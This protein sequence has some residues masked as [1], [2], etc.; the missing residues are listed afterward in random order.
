MLWRIL[1][2]HIALLRVAL[3]HHAALLWVALIH[4]AALL[5]VALVHHIALLRVALVHHIALLWVAL[6]HHVT[7][8]W[9]ALVHHTALL[10]VALVHHIALLRVALV[11]HAIAINRCG[12][13]C[14]GKCS[15]D[16]ACKLF[17]IHHFSSF[18]IFY[19]EGIKLKVHIIKPRC[20]NAKFYLVI[21]RIVV[22]WWHIRSGFVILIRVFL[23]FSLLI[24]V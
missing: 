6:V 17:I 13:R 12:C 14:A 16:L 18:V 10:W 21:I 7:L 15:Y 11:H 9:V 3:V 8:L 22:S 19:R 4:H 23:F 24:D 2:H 20:V 5:W 1:I